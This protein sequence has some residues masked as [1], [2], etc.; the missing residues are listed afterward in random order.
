M[1]RG[2][3]RNLSIRNQDYLAPSEHISPIKANTGYPNK[4]EKQDLG[5]KSHFMM[6]MEDFK[7]DIHISRKEIQDNTSKQV[8]ALKEEAERSLKELQ[9]KNNQTGEGNEQNHPGFKNGNRNNKEAQRETTLEI[10]Y[11]K[12]RSGF[13]DASITHKIQE[14]R[15]RISGAEDT[16]QNIDKTIKDNVKH[17]RLLA[18]NIQEIQDT[19]RRSN[20]TNRDRRE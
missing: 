14:I 9:E 8:E 1:T 15:E 11:L 17:K 18:K 19:K 10:E 13:I 7:K 20:L 2:K 6:M 3:P 12:K 16:I 5:I 4:L